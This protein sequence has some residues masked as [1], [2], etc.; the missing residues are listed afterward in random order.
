VLLKKKSAKV[1]KKRGGKGYHKGKK[2]SPYHNRS[3]LVLLQ[4]RKEK[5]VKIRKKRIG[6]NMKWKRRK[7][8]PKGKLPPENARYLKLRDSK[9]L[10]KNIKK[11]NPA[12]PKTQRN[13]A[14]G[15]KKILQITDI[16][17]G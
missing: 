2:T 1:E 13:K 14:E 10:E 8:E 16:E 17:R 15:K 11:E 6:R 12:S 4:G 5:V 7:L 9:G 3:H